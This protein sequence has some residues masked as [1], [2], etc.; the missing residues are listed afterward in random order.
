MQIRLAGGRTSEEG[1]VEVL[2]PRGSAS[3]WGAVCGEHWGLM[4]AMVACRQMGLGFAS[5]ALQVS[6]CLHCFL[7]MIST[8][9]TSRMLTCLLSCKDGT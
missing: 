1:V 4:E 3:R 6:D 9:C 5:H 8:E 2:V 7:I